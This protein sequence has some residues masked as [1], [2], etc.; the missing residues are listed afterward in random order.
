MVS[1]K[2]VSTLFKDYWKQPS[3]RYFTIGLL[4]FIAI[5][6]LYKL[7]VGH[8]NSQQMQAQRA[9]FTDISMYNKAKGAKS[10]ADSVNS[11]DVEVTLEDVDIALKNSAT[12]NSGTTLEPFFKAYESVVQTEL[13]NNEAAKD[14]WS[15]AVELLGASDTSRMSY[16]YKIKLALMDIDQSV[17]GGLDRLRAL[18]EDNQNKFN[19]LA[20][21][22]LGEYYFS[23]A[24]YKLAKEYFD[25]VIELNPDSDWA[26]IA[27]TKME[28]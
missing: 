3:N 25:K 12:E 15:R 11:S 17:E 2:E 23:Q 18:A 1:Q 16:L 22:Y 26:K 5:F 4:G 27:K 7:Y 9:F 10:S 8:N 24:D 13:G 19:D 20:N 6:G 28:G 14:T 21:Y